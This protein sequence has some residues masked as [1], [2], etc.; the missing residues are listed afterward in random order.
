MKFEGVFTAL[1]TPFKENGTLDEKG[2][3][4]LIARQ[5]NAH[6]HGI[7]VLGTT[8]EEPTL[9]PEEK[10]KV[11][12][13]SRHLIPSSTLLIVG[14]GSYST[15]ST[16]ANTKKAKDLGADACL[17]VTPYYNRPTQEGLYLHFE[18]L[19]NAVK[20]PLIIYNIASRTGQ[21]LAT[22][23]LKRIA[24][25][26]NIKGVKEASGSLPQVMEVIELIVNEN[27]EFKVLSG[28]DNF[29]FPLMCL[30]GH[31]VISVLSNLVPEL[32]LELYRAA[33]SERYS[34]A[35]QLHYALLPLM[36]AL[37]IETNPIPI[38]TL[39]RYENHPAGPCRLPL[40]AL[41][42]ENEKK[43]LHI[44]ETLKLPILHA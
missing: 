16:I 44:L 24:A 41:T 10:E 43:L 27:K 31:G 34:T 20:I 17:I 7:V 25:L 21:N 28:D 33:S 22:P 6:V 42:P 1:I 14:T 26:Q 36:Q 5:L 13:L 23:T 2:L 19:S 38:K 35:R 4:F 30:G 37:F 40:C 3:E 15:Q 11:I 8:G 9:T 32:I 12:R 29:F 39:M 18:A